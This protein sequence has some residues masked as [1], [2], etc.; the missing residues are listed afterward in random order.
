M[1]SD[2]I[3][4]T[5]EPGRTTG[6][7][8]SKRLRAEGK[9]PGVVYGH[10]NDPLSVAVERRDLRAAL[11]TEAGMNALIN[12]DVDGDVH[13]TI[14]RDV[15]RNP[16]RNEV[17]H[18]D[19]IIIDRDEVVT[20]E[21]PIVFLGEAKA[22][23]DESGNVDQQSFTLTVKAKPGSIPN[24]VTL[25]ISGMTI[26]D[27]L[28]VSDIPLPAGATTEADPDEPI[29]VA[30]ITRSTLEVE[31][32]EAEAEAAAEAAA[33][34]DGAEGEGEGGEAEAAAEGGEDAGE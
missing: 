12:L 25:D 1:P 28:R 30:M 14:V 18:V 9:I 5:A 2:E 23:M 13:L 8:P 6:S 26:G 34:V 20:V 31:A 15:Q 32:E 22:V 24:E 16:V 4:L 29:A 3:T 17:T 10:G 33:E 19:F 11:T 7:A 27:T 21:V